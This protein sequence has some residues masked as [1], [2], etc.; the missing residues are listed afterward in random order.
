MIFPETNPQQ[1][2][3]DY[4]ARRNWARLTLLVL[5]IGLY[6]LFVQ[7]P[8]LLLDKLN[9]LPLAPQLIL[10][11]GIIGVTTIPFAVPIL[12]WV[13]W[14]CPRCGEKFVQ[15]KVQWLFGFLSLA[16]YIAWRLVFKWRC[17]TCK[18]PC[19][20]DPGLPPRR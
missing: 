12:R 1:M 13:E 20:A 11:F 14:R 2:W 3:R 4:Y 5:P 15:P 16:V 10:V 7:P 19:G 8:L 6:V 18:L 17:A 9:A